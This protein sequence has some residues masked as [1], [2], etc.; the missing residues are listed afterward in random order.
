MEYLWLRTT[1][2]SYFKQQQ[3]G[4]ARD[5]EPITIGYIKDVISMAHKFI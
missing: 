3:M 1:V 5:Q 4:C 2:S